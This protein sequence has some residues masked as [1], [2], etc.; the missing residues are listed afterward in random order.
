MLNLRPAFDALYEALVATF[1]ALRRM[2]P[3]LPLE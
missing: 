1:L 2:R 3:G